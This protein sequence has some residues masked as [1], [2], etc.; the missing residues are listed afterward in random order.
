[1]IT[2]PTIAGTSCLPLT[3]EQEALWVEWKLSPTGVSYNTCVQTKLRGDVDIERFAKAASDV[4]GTF[5]LLRAFCHELDG[6]VEMRLSDERYQIDIIDVS[7]SVEEES[8]DTRRKAYAT[9]TRRRDAAIDLTRFPLIRAALVK[10]GARDFYFIGV[11]PHII[12]DGFSALFVLQAISVVYDRGLAG[13][14]ELLG[15]ERKDWSDYLAW[16][17]AQDPGRRDAAIAHWQQAL[18][19]ANHHIPICQHEGSVADTHGKRRYLE[20][21][22]SITAAWSKLTRSKRTSLFSALAALYAVFLY[23]LAI[24]IGIGL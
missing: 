24:Q 19:G 5:Q 6:K 2:D 15:D 3:R 20:L 14:D 10:S 8:A 18:A 12:S 13:L 22:S 17:A 16:R 11:V 23:G 9:L 1:M 4:A 7:D 21:D